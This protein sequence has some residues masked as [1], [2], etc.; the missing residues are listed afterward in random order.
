MVAPIEKDK[1]KK[2][3]EM[4]AAGASGELIAATTGI[5]NATVSRYRQEDNIRALIEQVQRE[6]I[7]NNISNIA[8]NITQ[9]INSYP[10][11][12]CKNEKSR[13]EKQ[14]AYR[15]IEKLAE[16]IG[17]YPSRTPS[18]MIANIYNDNRSEL[19]DKVLDIITRH[20]N[21]FPAD[22]AEGEIIDA[23]S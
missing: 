11:N 18:T 2:I 13:A 16:T 12:D 9:L 15:A 20:A 6:I 1:I 7:T 22:P 5:S 17:I 23:E 19:S 4:T 3:V 14:H 8:K 10:D 21:Q